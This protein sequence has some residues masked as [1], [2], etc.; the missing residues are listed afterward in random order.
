MGQATSSS[1]SSSSS[2]A[3]AATARA[4]ERHRLRYRLVKLDTAHRVAM[5]IVNDLEEKIREQTLRAASAT[6]IPAVATLALSQVRALKEQ[7]ADQAVQIMETMQTKKLTY[8][9]ISLLDRYENL[10]TTH[11]FMASFE[12][13]RPDLDLMEEEVAKIEAVIGDN[14]LMTT[15]LE[16]VGRFGKDSVRATMRQYDRMQ[17]TEAA[18]LDEEIELEMALAE[19]RRTASTQS[20][21]PPP[22]R[23]PVVETA[24]GDAMDEMAARLLKMMPD[25]PLDPPT[26]QRT[27]LRRAARKL[28]AS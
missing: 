23:P 9:N 13:A 22:P 28:P 3:A 4:A 12:R 14:Q 5:R 18:T 15:R 2:T 16:A 17:A 7:L 8:S 24:V 25:V 10:T 27:G 26:A 19:D 20:S 1:S 11:D 6:S 21:P